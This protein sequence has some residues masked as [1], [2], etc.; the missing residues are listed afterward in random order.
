MGMVPKKHG[1]L[2]PK[3]LGRGMP[4]S[5]LVRTLVLVQHKQIMRLV[6]SELSTY[7]ILSYRKL[8]GLRN[9]YHS[10]S[11]SLRGLPSLTLSNGANFQFKFRSDILIFHESQFQTAGCICIWGRRLVEAVDP[12]IEALSTAKNHLEWQL[13]SK[14]VGSEDCDRHRRRN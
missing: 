13:E 9:G 11:K 2:F 14:N 12:M 1:S 4:P 10:T 7:Y 6:V 8:C 5:F 3:S